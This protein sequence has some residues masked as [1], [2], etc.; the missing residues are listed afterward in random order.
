VTVTLLDPYRFTTTPGGSG[1]GTAAAA[2]AL[3]A[4]TNGTAV[5]PGTAA[6][7]FALTG[8]AAGTGGASTGAALEYS[9][10]TDALYSDNAAVQYLG[11]IGAR[12]DLTFTATA[13]GVR[14][15]IGSTA[16]APFT[17]TATT[18]G[19]NQKTG[20]ATATF[21]LTA[22]AAGSS[23]ASAQWTDDFNSTAALTVLRGGVTSTGTKL[24]C[25]TTSSICMVTGTTVTN[26]TNHYSQV[27]VATL[28]SATSEAGVGLRY[29]TATGAHFLGLILPGGGGQCEFYYYNGS[30][31]T[32]LSSGSV[33]IGTLPGT[34]RGEINGSGTNNLTLKWRGV[35]ILQATS[36]AILTGK[37]TTHQQASG[38]VAN[39]ELESWAAD[40]L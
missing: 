14:T 32:L 27:E 12:T 18:S 35:T 36:N 33:T 26:T 17:L 7:A 37:P 1:T 6:A 20:T 5:R 3:T 22:T 21:A 9:D 15:A 23:G 30:F 31:Y 40:I 34:L 2:F 28:T 39:C 24:R 25:S 19:G 8:T 16:A 11:N 38:S 29:D 4:T 10:G 13:A